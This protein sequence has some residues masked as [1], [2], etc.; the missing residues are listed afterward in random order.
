MI[1]GLMNQ[2]GGVGKSTLAT[3]LAVQMAQWGRRVLLIDA[4]PQGS[5]LDWA[6]Q[7]GHNDH[8]SV[9][10][11]AGFPRDT[12]HREIKT[13]GE[14]YDDIIIDGPGRIEAIV[15]SA[16]LACDV[17][18]I[19]VQPSPFDIWASNEV[20]N[21][22][23]QSI[24]YKPE[25]KSVFVINRKVV[26]TT[27]GKSVRSAVAD[28]R[29]QLLETTVAQRIDFTNAASAGLAVCEYAPGSSAD[30]EIRALTKELEE[31]SG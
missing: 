8:P 30:D 4:D 10:T 29:P 27:I 16:M 31:I 19:P 5:C 7:R 11:V 18:V 22:I 2:K 6:A 3:N 21:L 26:N 17:V 24:I 14:G 12:L 20:L 15:R 9:I 28:H 25:L 23:D 13:M 1:Y